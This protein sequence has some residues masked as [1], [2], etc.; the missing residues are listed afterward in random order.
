MTVWVWVG[1]VG[2][3]GWGLKVWVWVKGVDEGVGIW[4]GGVVSHRPHPAVG[5]SYE[6]GTPVWVV[7]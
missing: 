5:V 1:G 7:G 4:S 6:R 2:I 3:E